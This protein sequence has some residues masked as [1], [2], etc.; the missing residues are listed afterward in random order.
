MPAPLARTTLSVAD[1]LGRPGASRPLALELDAPE[2]LDLPLVERLDRLR[3]DGVLE[4]LA[5][6]V[7]VRGT[8]STTVEM[9]CARCLR[10]LSAPV[11]ADVAELY[12]DPAGAEDPADVEPGYAIRD[13]LI[14]L[15]AL[16][17][18]TL[19]PRIPVAPL[20]DP[21]CKG[22]CPTCGADRNLTDCSCGEQP[23]DL[24]WSALEGL[25]LDDR[26]P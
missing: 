11:E 16:V 14:D 9:A 15:D 19:V 18:D 2:G 7:L 6:G 25:R 22:L 13:G 26:T 20:H 21:D 23:V 17:R 3:L 1:L 4:S 24:R 10:P 5:E 12:A 8:L